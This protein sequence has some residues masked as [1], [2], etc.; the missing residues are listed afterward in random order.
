MAPDRANVASGTP[1]QIQSN[2]GCLNPSTIDGATGCIYGNEDSKKIALVLGDP[3]AMSWIPGIATA[4]GDEYQIRGIGYGNCPFATIEVSLPKSPGDAERCALA[5]DQRARTIAMLNP[6]LLIVSDTEMGLDRAIVR[7]PI[8]RAAEWQAA[9]ATSLDAA[10]AAT[11]AARIVVLT[12]PP[13]TLAIDVCATS[14]SS[15]AQCE[16]E[17]RPAWR[18]KAVSEEAA[19]AA[20]G[21][22]FDD[23]SQWFCDGLRCPAFAG[24][25]IMRT[26]GM[27]L[28][29]PYS[30]SRAP[31]LRH[32][33]STAKKTARAEKSG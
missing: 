10:K 18:I 26:D 24:N 30:E 28:T 14:G 8:D 6:D 17:S 4:I 15:P 7:D 21:V 20:A 2:A 11:P 31:E 29:T 3:V 23:T 19:A 1:V 13:I 16:S 9:F 5:R 27:H 33:L 12:P 25:I 32:A 22:E